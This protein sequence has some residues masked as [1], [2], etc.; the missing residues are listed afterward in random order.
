MCY[1]NFKRFYSKELGGNIFVPSHIGRNISRCLVAFHSQLFSNQTGT[2]GI[3]L[4]F[5]PFDSGLILLASYRPIARKTKIGSYNK[6]TRNMSRGLFA[7]LSSIHETDF[8]RFNSS[9]QVSEKN[10]LA[11]RL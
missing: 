1:S 4:H 6:K 3:V 9:R 7:S 11:N 2:D 8:S 5:L 10:S